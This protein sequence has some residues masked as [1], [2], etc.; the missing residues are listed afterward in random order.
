MFNEDIA[1]HD[2]L[3]YNILK[4]VNI[5]GIGKTD[6]TAE[7]YFFATTS[8]YIVYILGDL[9]VGILMIYLI[10]F[11]IYICLRIA[12]FAWSVGSNTK[13]AINGSMVDFDKIVLIICFVFVV[14]ILICIVI[15][16]YYF[17]NVIHKEIIDIKR[18][19]NDLDTIIFTFIQSMNEEL[20]EGY[21][22]VISSRSKDMN[23]INSYFKDTVTKKYEP[24]SMTPGSQYSKSIIQKAYLYCLFT[25]LV[26]IV[27]P[28]NK[29]LTES[30]Y[31]FF[32]KNSDDPARENGFLSFI[33]FLK[34]NETHLIT[35]KYYELEIFNDPTVIKDN[36]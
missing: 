27:P 32:T 31:N 1:T 28:S 8:Q 36:T 29:K 3:S 33:S 24:A 18:S 16:K 14:Y 35:K 34:Y 21:C 7:P 17:S 11:F 23:L 26:E 22:K 4:Y 19:H 6:M 9:F 12:V 25:Y 13:M 15:Y 30:I 2:T 20:D 5:Q 10:T